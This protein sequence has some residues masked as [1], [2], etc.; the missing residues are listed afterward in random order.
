[1]GTGRGFYKLIKEAISERMLMTDIEGTV[2]VDFSIIIYDGFSS[3][4]ENLM[5]LH[6]N[7]PRNIP[8]LG[9]TIRQF[10]LS[11]K[12]NDINYLFMLDGL[13]HP[14]KFASQKRQRRSDEA[15]LGRALKKL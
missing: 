9:V 12:K 6:E 15:K 2:V 13:P 5:Q 1:M 11:M 14:L 3:N 7:P 8:W 4:L 10:E